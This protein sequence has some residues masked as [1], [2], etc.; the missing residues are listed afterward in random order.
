MCCLIT[1]SICGVA[2]FVFVLVYVSGVLAERKRCQRIS[3][4]DECCRRWEP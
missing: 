4:A 3:Y 2:L 1:Q